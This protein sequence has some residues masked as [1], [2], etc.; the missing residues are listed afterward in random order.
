M[1]SGVRQ[2][3]CKGGGMRH[4]HTL[5]ASTKTWLTPSFHRLCDSLKNEKPSAIF[6][7]K[8][9]TQQNTSSASVMGI[10]M[11]MGSEAVNAATNSAAIGI[12]IEPVASVDEQMAA[13]TTRS[14]AVGTDSHGGS[15]GGGGG[16]GADLDGMQTEDGGGS[17]DSL[18]L[19]RPGQ[20]DPVMQT[21]MALALA[22]KIA[23]N[24]FSYLSSF[25]P[26]SAP[27]TVPLLK[28]WLEQF[29]RKLKAQG[30]GFLARADAE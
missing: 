22:P 21:N 18:A 27:Q 17:N 3:A 19:V 15:G 9:L 25:A 4:T 11:G 29:E 10:G 28:R 1:V 26:D 14:G 5:S 30:I 24:I 23:S 7:I 2:S 13:L 6:R 20:L 16:G 8:G 12:S